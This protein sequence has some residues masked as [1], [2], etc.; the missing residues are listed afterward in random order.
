MWTSEMEG[1]HRGMYTAGAAIGTVRKAG[2]KR[3]NEQGLKVGN[4]LHD[5]G[6]RYLN[7]GRRAGWRNISAKR[8]R[9]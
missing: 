3:E 4:A 2:F 6:T 9:S 1:E 8:G 7:G 5:P